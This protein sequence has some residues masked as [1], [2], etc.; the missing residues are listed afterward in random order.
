MLATYHLAV[1]S[2]VIMMAARYRE[3]SIRNTLEVRELLVGVDDTVELRTAINS[4]L[5]CRQHP[6]ASQ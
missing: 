6:V 2:C 5:Q 1:A 3:H 4:L